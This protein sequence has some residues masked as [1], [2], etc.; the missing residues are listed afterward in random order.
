VALR[1]L[2]DHLPP[3]GTLVPAQLLCPFLCGRLQEAGLRGFAP[4]FKQRPHDAALLDA[5][6]RRDDLDVR[7]L[8]RWSAIRDRR[9]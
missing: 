1:D 8:E 3:P 2:A 7:Q 5:G 4:L 6:T 9:S